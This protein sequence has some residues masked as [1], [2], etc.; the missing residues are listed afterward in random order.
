[1]WGG[2]GVLVASWVADNGQFQKRMAKK[3]LDLSMLCCE[4]AWANWLLL[5]NFSR[6]LQDFTTT[7]TGQLSTVA[8]SFHKEFAS[9]SKCFTKKCDSSCWWGWIIK[10]HKNQTKK[11]CVQLYSYTELSFDMLR[12]RLHEVSWYDNEPREPNS[13]PSLSFD[14]WRF[15]LDVWICVQ[16]SDG[17]LRG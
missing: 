1:M 4:L 6:S 9:D 17:E 13:F 15:W 10:S 7:R 16:L 11:Y 5:D 3:C 14:M 2:W 12:F 8:S